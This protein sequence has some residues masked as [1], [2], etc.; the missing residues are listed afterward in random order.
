VDTVVN[1]VY[2]MHEDVLR[3]NPDFLEALNLMVSAKYTQK[4]V[5]KVNLTEYLSTAHANLSLNLDTV[6]QIHIMMTKY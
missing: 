6:I 3:K 4:A 5:R 2:Y 1:I